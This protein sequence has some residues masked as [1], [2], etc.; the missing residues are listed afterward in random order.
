[1]SNE[2]AKKDSEI[3]TILLLLLFIILNVFLGI[4]FI[5]AINA[6]GETVQIQNITVVDRYTTPG[7]TGVY[8][9]VFR[10]DDMQKV[11]VVTTQDLFESLQVG[12]QGNAVVEYGYTFGPDQTLKQWN[13]ISK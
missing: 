1:M 10:L 2:K 6:E 4:N 12:D 8:T 9:I 11:R 5:D 13:P 7:R 3:G